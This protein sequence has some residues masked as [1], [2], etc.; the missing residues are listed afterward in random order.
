VRQSARPAAF[1]FVE[2]S[3]DRYCVRD[4][5]RCAGIIFGS[6]SGSPSPISIMCS[7]ELPAWRMRRSNTSSVMSSLGCLCVSRGHMGQYKLHLAVVSTIYST[8]SAPSLERRARYPH[9]RLRAVPDPHVSSIVH[10]V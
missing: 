3:V 9:N 1:R 2:I 6:I 7:A 8:G 4:R 10:V 5:I